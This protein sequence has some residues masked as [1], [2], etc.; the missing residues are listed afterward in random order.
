MACL[1]GEWLGQ[2]SHLETPGFLRDEAKILRVLVDY[3]GTG[4]SFGLPRLVE[5][6]LGGPPPARPVHVVVVSDSDLFG[7]IDRTD[8]GWELA[9][10]ALAR[11]GGGGTAVLRLARVPQHEVWLEKL[12]DAGFSTEIVSSEAEL[13][14]FARAFAKRTFGEP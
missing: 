5:T 3:L 6:F 9:R 2:G 12:R 7:E 10:R 11:A 14:S 13:V 8:R 1:S 4:A